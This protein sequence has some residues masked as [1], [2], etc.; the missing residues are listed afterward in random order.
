LNWTLSVEN[1]M[2]YQFIEGPELMRKFEQQVRQ[3]PIDMAIGENV[4]AVSRTDGGFEVTTEGGDKHEGLTVIVST[5]KAP[6]SLDVPGE[7]ELIGRGVSYCATCDGPLFAGMDVAVVGGG[8]SALEAALDLAKTAR[9]IHLISLTPLTADHVL[10]EK[11][12]ELPAVTIL[13]EHETVKISGEDLV[14]GI[15]VRDLLTGR[16]TDL[17]V[18]G[19]FVEIGL[20]PNSGPVESLLPLNLLGEIQVTCANETGIPGLFAAGDVTNVPEKQV[21]VSA[22]EGAKAALQAHRYLQRR[23]RVCQSI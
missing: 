10:I 3:F 19:V 4:K 23:G 7:K 22:G 15:T 2:G 20:I 8:N 16:E 1:Y 6:R 17:D 18:Q 11:V 14:T 12:R 21:V 13:M 5:G 9:K